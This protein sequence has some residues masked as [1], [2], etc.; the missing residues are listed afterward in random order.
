MTF[1]MGVLVGMVILPAG[2]FAAYGFAAAFEKRVVRDCNACGVTVTGWARDGVGRPLLVRLQWRFHAATARHRY[3]RALWRSPENRARMEALRADYDRR[4][5][6][7]E[8][9]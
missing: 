3:L 2:A 5:A 7:G 4:A 6:S 9:L 8:D 1:W